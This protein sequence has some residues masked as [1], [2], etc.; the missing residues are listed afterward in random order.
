MEQRLFTKSAF[1]IA[2]R[3]PAAL[4]YYRD[5]KTY[6]NQNSGDEFLHALAEG[7]FQV[8][9]LAKIY[10][11]VDDG[12]DLEALKGYEESLA[13][14]DELMSR[15]KVVIAEAAYRYGDMFVRTDIIVKDGT[16][17]K[18]IE[19]KAKSWD[20]GESGFIVDKK[21]RKKGDPV[22][23]IL[24][25]GYGEYLYDVA[26]QKYVVQHAL[27][28]KY[29]AGRFHIEAYLM[30][31][32]K[33]AV[34]DV[35]GMNQCFE[36]VRDAKG[37]SHVERRGNAEALAD[38][39][40]VVR[41]V[42]VD[43][44]CARIYACDL[45]DSSEFLHGMRFEE[46]VQEMC[47]IYCAHERR[48]ED[49]SAACFSCPFYAT[50]K[51]RE[52]RPTIR[53]GY[54]EC[55]KER[56]HFTDED[57]KLPTIDELN[58]TGKRRGDLI[59]NHRLRLADITLPDL[60]SAS[61]P[62][63]D[64]VG[65]RPFERQWIQAAVST[66]R[67]DQLVGL[68]ANMHKDAMCNDVYIDV[69]GLRAE[70][71]GWKFPLHMID[72]ETSA[73]AL[74]FYEN[75]HPYETIAFQF[76]HHVIDS[77]DGGQTYSIRHEGQYINTKKGFFPN[78]EFVR[79]LKAQLEK[80]GGS[81][82]R[83]C[84]HE[85]SV[86]NQIRQQLLA[87]NE[88]D[89]D[90]LVAFIESITHRSEIGSDGKEH[91]VPPPPRDMIDLW[92]VVKRYF[93]HPEMKGSNSIK[94]VLPAV[95]NASRF[96]QEKYARPIYGSEIPSR[97]IPRDAPIPWITFDAAGHVENPYKH[98]PPISSYFPEESRESVD[99]ACEGDDGEDGG[100]TVA[101]GGAALWAYGMMQFTDG[102]DSEALTKALLRYCELDTMAMVFIWEYFNHMCEEHVGSGSD[103]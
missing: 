40:H 42:N 37:R 49:I 57:L 58:G 35:N 11:K 61:A 3:C 8:G 38:C 83:Y 13:K 82:F 75:M 45:D 34:A 94:F 2:L 31:A 43:H 15:D 10:C 25:D 32:D 48:Y 19:I 102:A 16:D 26:F 78:F 39:R 77:Q 97:N 24:Q 62:G 84:S 27:D 20:G 7:G 93:W 95:L 100:E 88:P 5:P 70:M 74:P 21:G 99:N 76:S 101:N 33:S 14:T 36:I 86:L 53:D 6:A 96:L 59:A 46:F 79:N 103:V 18:L 89:K 85:N 12:C 4:Y 65:L 30:M 80:D 55:W 64:A 71:S 54:D 92:K 67:V 73:V 60:Q 52:K 72:F 22:R 9:D 69:D 28:E 44:E 56:A 91:D 87:S 66:N 29:G 17:I 63:K 51:D 23:T 98:L 90:A 81:V 50:D 68:R 41:A 1:K 47:R